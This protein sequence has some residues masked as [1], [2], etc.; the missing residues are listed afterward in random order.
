MASAHDI[1]EGGLGVALAE[2]TFKTPFGVTVTWQAPSAWLF[3][4]TPGRF[5]VSVPV[6]KA[7][8]FEELMGATATKLGIVTT[9]DVLSIETA[10]EELK[11][12]K[13][14]LQEIYEEAITWQRNQ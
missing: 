10:T 1:A 14:T 13:R 2:S 6:D 9:D 3:S 5:V 12:A 8:A 11:L 4:E 7:I